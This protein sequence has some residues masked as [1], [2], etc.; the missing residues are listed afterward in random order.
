V[1]NAFADLIKLL[2]G[3][4]VSF[5]MEEVDGVTVAYLVIQYGTDIDVM[6]EIQRMERGSVAAAAR[7]LG[8][9]REWER[10]AYDL[11]G[12]GVQVTRMALFNR[13]KTVYADLVQKGRTLTVALSGSEGKYVSRAMGLPADGVITTLFSAEVDIQKYAPFM[14]R[15]VGHEPAPVMK[16]MLAA[17]PPE[18]KMTLSANVKEGALELRYEVP[19]PMFVALMKLATDFGA[20]GR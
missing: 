12:Q 18:S 6:A 13:E 3:D 9:T 4:S 8:S 19:M 15:H 10:S 2:I 7:R 16:Q 1:E 20:P 11:Q 5:A 14:K 17:L